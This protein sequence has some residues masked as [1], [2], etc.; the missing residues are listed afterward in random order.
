MPRAQRPAPGRVPLC[1]LGPGML[2]SLQLPSPGCRRSCAPALP[3][4]QVGPLP[5]GGCFCRGG[6][7]SLGWVFKGLQRLLMFLTGAGQRKKVAWERLSGSGSGVLGAAGR[8]AAHAACS[9]VCTQTNPRCTQRAPFL[10]HVKQ[11]QRGCW[12]GLACRKG[13]GSGA[14]AGELCLSHTSLP[15]QPGQQGWSSREPNCCLGSCVREQIALLL[16]RSLKGF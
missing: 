4:G 15:L 16:L 10:Q 7:A 1:S 2:C 8:E 12:A 11:L 5:R 6:A 3:S 14:A 13:E 9:C